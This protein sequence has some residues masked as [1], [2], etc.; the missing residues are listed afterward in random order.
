[1]G[2]SKDPK[3]AKKRAKNDSFLAMSNKKKIMKFFY[4]NLDIVSVKYKRLET[5]KKFDPHSHIRPKTG[6]E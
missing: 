5:A 4:Q 2:A 3:I 6:Q 1:M